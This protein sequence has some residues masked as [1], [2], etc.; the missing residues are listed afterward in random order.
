VIAREARRARPGFRPAPRQRLDVYAP[1]APGPHPVL[2][3]LYG[4][5]WQSGRREDYAFAGEAFAGRGFRD[6]V[7]DYRLVPEA[8]FPPF[9]EDAAAAAAWAVRNAARF[10]GDPARLGVAGHSAGAYNALMLALDPRFLARQ[11]RPAR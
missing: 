11:A 1:A 9:I 2:L 8:V 5:S 7:A 4:G 10:G 3:W 6:A